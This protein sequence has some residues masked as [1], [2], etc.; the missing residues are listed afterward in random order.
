MGVD[1]PAEIDGAGAHLDGETDLAEQVARV[2]ADD[3]AADHPPHRRVEEQLGEA[4]VTAVG[5]RPADRGSDLD[6]D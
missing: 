1:R 3:A 2:R 6:A 4:L 5:D